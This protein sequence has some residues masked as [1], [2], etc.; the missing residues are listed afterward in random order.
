MK[1]FFLLII[2]FIIVFSCKKN[3]DPPA[4]TL[5]TT[6]VLHYDNFPDGWGLYYLTDSSEFLILKDIF[7]SESVQFQHYKNF[8]NLHS[9]LFFKDNGEKGCLYGFGPSCGHRV[10]EVSGIRYE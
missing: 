6:G 5:Q 8:V 1:K 2:F 4:G 10:V 7:P 3:S 9:R